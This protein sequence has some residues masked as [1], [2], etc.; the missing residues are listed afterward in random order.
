M[1]G[2]VTISPTMAFA[3]KI[4]DEITRFHI[5]NDYPVSEP[6]R[7][8]PQDIQ[9]MYTEQYNNQTPKW[10]GD[11]KLFKPGDTGLVW[12]KAFWVDA[13]LEP[14]HAWVA[15]REVVA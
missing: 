13:S 1:S 8:S 4:L 12:G 10:R 15:G 7:L 6:I 5:E 11:Y 2:F 9:Q 3:E 14:G